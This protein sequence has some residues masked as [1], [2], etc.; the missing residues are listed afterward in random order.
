MMRE[1]I[2]L[3][4]EMAGALALIDL[5]GASAT[6]L[7]RLKALYSTGT[8]FLQMN[9]YSTFRQAVT[10]SSFEI[11]LPEIEREMTI[12]LALNEE[13]LQEAI[14]RGQQIY[15]FPIYHTIIRD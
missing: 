6:E 1:R 9:S 14:D 4:L 8:V 10:D 11:L 12:L 7:T 13:D 15:D 3:Q 5:R 2:L